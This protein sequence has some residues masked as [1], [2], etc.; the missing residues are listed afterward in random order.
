M[1]RIILLSF[2]VSLFLLASC[3]KDA[4]TDIA[5]PVKEKAVLHLSLCSPSTRAT[6]EDTPDEAN[7]NSIQV[8]V[9]AGDVLDGYKM[10]SASEISSMVVDVEATAGLRD[11]YVVVNALDL[12]GI[13]SKSSLLSNITRLGET[14]SLSDASSGSLTYPANAFVM[15]GHLSD[16]TVGASYSGTIAVNRYAARVHLSKVTRA[17]SAASLRDKAFRINRVYLTNVVTNEKLDFDNPASYTWMNA[18]FGADRTI[19]A[20]NRYVCQSAETAVVADGASYS[21]VHSLYALANEYSEDDE[22]RPMTY[23]CTRLVV[24]CSIDVDGSGVFEDDEYYTYPIRLGALASNKSYEIIELVITKL[25]N[26][27]NGDDFADD[28]EDDDINKV[29]ASATVVVND[30]TEVLIG[31]NGVYT[32]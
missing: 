28:G 21:A 32:I 25:G 7:V 22:A 15:S 26:R 19:S 4:G 30:W 8:F 24:E 16:Q 9:F 12:S 27:S 2:A 11:I 6:V 10:A 1:K 29:A 23:R 20:G 3:D 14:P 13:S 5:A 31:D 18:S 17:F